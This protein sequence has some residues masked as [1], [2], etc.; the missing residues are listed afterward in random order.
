M[1]AE[2]NTTVVEQFVST[3]CNIIIILSYIAKF[4]SLFWMLQPLCYSNAA[5]ICLKQCNAVVM[6]IEFHEL[7]S[8]NTVLFVVTVMQ[9]RNELCD[10]QQ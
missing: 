4:H 10:H 6:M 7:Q 3:V 1:I 8:E 2:L 9:N 5:W